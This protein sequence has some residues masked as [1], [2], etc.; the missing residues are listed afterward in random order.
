MNAN[1]YKPHKYQEKAIQFVV[2]RSEA[3]LF[4]D[5]GLGKTSIM[6]AAL[7]ILRRVDFVKTMLV[8]A[9][10]RPCYGVWPKEVKKWSDFE[11]LS[12]GVLHGAQKEKV[13]REKHQIYVINSEGLQWLS[14]KLRG[15][16]FPFDILVVD[17]SSKFKA[18]NTQRFKT[19]KQLLPKFK[20]RY[21]L[22]GT[23]APNS[24]MDLFG[25]VLIMDLGK[26]FGPYVT[27][28][29]E[30]Y[31][32]RTGFG[33][34]TW[35]LKPDGMQAIHDRLAPKVLRMSAEDYLELPE[36]IIEDIVVELPPKVMLMY[37]QL[38]NELRL[39]FLEGRVS[40]V[41]SAVAS[42]KCRQIANGGIYLDG[43]ADDAGN[44]A[45]KH[46]HDAKID[47]VEDLIEELAGQPALI[48]YEF[49][50]DLERLLK[51]LGKDT[52]YIGGGVSGAQSDKHVDAWNRGELKALLGHPQSMA[53]GLNMQQK[54]RAIIWAA[55]PW[56]LELYDQFIRRVW[57]QGQKERVFVYRII[58][59]GTVDE[60]IVKALSSKD[61]SQQA[62]FNALK[63]YWA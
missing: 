3:G 32:H 24:L 46:L 18:V 41:N 63:D 53:H 20:R 58:A 38:E 27:K 6:L 54:G 49:K 50:H 17:E 34:Y 11:N 9:P 45:W 26:T 61:R 23:P 2:E 37:K 16:S 36:L 62:L 56:S 30:E 14:G 22:T 5:P 21:I 35:T 47:A 57:R 15:E 48:A 4:L 8:V 7:K 10:L 59:K 1:P 52:P 51:L 13:L 33:G 19:L 43:V 60:A 29:R 55:L 39:D 28:F 31:F 12:V 25:Q 40:A 44:R 42:M